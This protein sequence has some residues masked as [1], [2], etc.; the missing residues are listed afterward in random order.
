MA[1]NPYGNGTYIL[2]GFG[3]PPVNYIYNSS[4]NSWE[5]SNDQIVNTAPSFTGSE[6]ILIASGSISI[7][8]STSVSSTFRNVQVNSGA[9]LTIDPGADLTVSKASTTPTI[10][11]SKT[12]GGDFINNG[13][14]VVMNS[15]ATN[16][17]SLIIAVM[18]LKYY[19]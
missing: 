2:T 16:F 19:L 3:V 18:L 14:A 8:S 17:S 6:S 9:T 13:G 15:D 10:G 1:D 4:W 7:G 11:T 12:W 5:S